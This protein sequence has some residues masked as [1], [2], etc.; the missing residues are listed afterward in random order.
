MPADSDNR[1]L[2]H[3]S[4]LNN[5]LQIMFNFLKNNVQN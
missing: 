4:I 5:F 2:V 1:K 3:D